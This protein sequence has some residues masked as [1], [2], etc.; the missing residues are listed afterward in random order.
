[1]NFRGHLET[2]YPTLFRE[3]A[4]HAYWR[5]RIVTPDNDFLD[6]DWLKQG[7]RKLVIIS[8]GLEGNSQ[9]AYV[10]GMG[11]AFY[12]N[13][14]DVLAWNCRG[15]SD[16]M[17]RALGFYHSGA[18]EDL[19]TVVDHAIDVGYETIFLIGFSL[20]GN[21]TLKYAGERHVNSKIRGIITF[22]VP[23]DLYSCSVQLSQPSNWIYA[24]R[25]LKS[26]KNKIQ[27]KSKLMPGLN[28]AGLEEIKSLKEF[29]DAYTGPLHGFKDA[30]DYYKK[31]SAISFIQ[32][33]KIPALMV[34]A[35]NDPFL[36]EECFPKNSGNNFVQ[37]EFP[38]F[39]GHVGFSKFNGNGLYW[40]EQRAIEFVQATMR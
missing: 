2:I 29:D 7:S 5:E 28:V 40:S 17:N 36:S 32:N 25:F 8:H 31:C 6:L 35:Q 23:I 16:E 37:F 1:M 20:G 18:T 15:C 22:S 33:I 12:G 9:R 24:N 21:L 26:L 27:T 38:K 19:S 13:G 4:L 30:M 10:K 34:N 11:K 14:F 39:G 3:V